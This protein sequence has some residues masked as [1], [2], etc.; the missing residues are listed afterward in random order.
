M[1]QGASEFQSKWP[2]HPKSRAQSRKKER[3]DPDVSEDSVLPASAAG[4]SELVT[5]DFA[6]DDEVWL[7]PTPGR[8]P[9]QVVTMLA[10][11]GVLGVTCGDVLHS[12]VQCPHPD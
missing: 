11:S 8:A 10:S 1:V 6:L 4:Q 3:P 5:D 12:P 7:E 2:C 9:G